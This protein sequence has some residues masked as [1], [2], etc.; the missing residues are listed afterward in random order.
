M[1]ENVHVRVKTSSNLNNF[2]SNSEWKFLSISDGERHSFAIPG[3]THA[4]KEAFY[5]D[6]YISEFTVHIK[7]ISSF[8]V[9]LFIWPLVFMLF[10]GL[11]IFIL[12]PSC[13]ERVSMGALLLLSL[14]VLSLILESFTPKS[15]SSSV[16]GNLIGEE[17]V[18]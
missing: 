13:V 8:Y 12:P 9:N 3:T 16:V 11:V 5:Y 6:W 15:P 18:T 7:R 2:R 17:C 4:A 14:V 10:V 1:L